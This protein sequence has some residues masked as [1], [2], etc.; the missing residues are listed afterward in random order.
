MS[1][2]TP[3]SDPGLGGEEVPEYGDEAVADERGKPVPVEIL[4]LGE[5]NP[6]RPIVTGD[7]FPDVPV[8][9][10]PQDDGPRLT[11]IVAHPSGMRRGARLEDRIRAAPIVQDDRLNPRK[12][13][14]GLPDIFQLPLLPAHIAGVELGEGRWGAR[15]DLAAS[16]DSSQ[17]DVQ[18]RCLCLSARGVALLVQ[19]IV[20]SD[21]RVMVREDTIGTMLAP[22]LLE[23]EWLE[24]WNDDLIRPLVEGGA[25]L[26]NELLRGAD[27]FES[28]MEAD[29]GDDRT[30]H[31]MITALESLPAV[32]AQRVMAQELRDRRDAA[33]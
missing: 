29:R 11:M 33:L 7:V 3:D 8:P 15:I 12:I 25:D 24:T 22:K 32:E 9:G 18:R 1:Q 13:V 17:F 28:V 21:T 16:V 14:P 4:Y 31:K 10:F 19:C 23:I 20:N 2:R 6:Y 26:H 30:L 27:E 5:T